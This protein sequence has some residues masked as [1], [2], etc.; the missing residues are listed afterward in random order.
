M[1]IWRMRFACWIPKAAN[2]HSEYVIRVAFSL[3][4]WLYER[5]SRLRFRKLFFLLISALARKGTDTEAV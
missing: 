2:I 4:Q 5:V 1:T 3:Q